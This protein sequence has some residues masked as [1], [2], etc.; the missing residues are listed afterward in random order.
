MAVLIL[1]LTTI[2]VATT[3]DSMSY[4]VSMVASGHDKPATSVRAFWGISMSVMAAIPLFIGEG[5]VSALQQFIV[6]TAIAVWLVIL[7]SLWL[8]P[9]SAH[10]LARKQKLVR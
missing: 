5:Q 6:I 8:G 3:G 9:K 7:P 10:A 2:F 1:V 4:T